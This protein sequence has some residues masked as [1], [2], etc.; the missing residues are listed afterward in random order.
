MSMQFPA[1]AGT[2][3]RAVCADREHT[4]AAAIL[5]PWAPVAAPGSCSMK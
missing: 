5:C 3:C 4:R 1:V 2:E